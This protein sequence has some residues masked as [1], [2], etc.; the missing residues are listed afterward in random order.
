[1]IRLITPMFGEKNE[2]RESAKKGAVAG[3]VSSILND[4]GKDKAIYLYRLYMN[5]PSHQQ[6]GLLP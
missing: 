3:L 6:L 5:L 2:H 1:M 4:W